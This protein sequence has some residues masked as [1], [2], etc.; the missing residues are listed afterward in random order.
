MLMEGA[1]L[2]SRL[3]VDQR[4]GQSAHTLPLTLATY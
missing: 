1:A 4:W 2:L 3:Y